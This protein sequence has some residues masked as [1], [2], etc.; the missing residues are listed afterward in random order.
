MTS[1]THLS[2]LF[3]MTIMVA[4]NFFS[5]GSNAVGNSGRIDIGIYSTGCSGFEV[6]LTPNAGFTDNTITNIQFTISWPQNTVNLINLNKNFNIEQQG[7]VQVANGMNHAIFASTEPVAVNWIAQTQYTLI[8]FS[9]DA[10][11]SGYG[12]FFIDESPWVVANNGMFYTEL[13]GIDLTGNVIH[14]VKNIFMG[15]CGI[16]EIRVLL[17]G[18]YNSVTGLM[19]T[20][21]NTAGTLPKNQTF[22]MPPWN[23]SGTEQVSSFPDSI[24]DWVLVELRDKTNTTQT[25]ERKAGLLSKSGLV[26]SADMT[27]GLFFNSI[28]NLSEFYI[29]VWHR[30]HMPVMSGLTVSFPNPGKPY[31]FSRITSTQPYKHNNPLPAE[32][33]LAVEGSGIYGMIAGDINGDKQLVYSGSGNDRALILSKIGTISGSNLLNASINGYY[34]EDITVDNQVDYTGASNDR[35]LILSNLNRLTGSSNLNIVYFSVVP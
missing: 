23:Y 19:S 2:R 4:I 30:N 7:P 13:L 31:D 10:S 25:I 27:S 8:S 12:S 33:E 14:D 26:L 15:R 18:P 16:A 6:R 20:A 32:L 29:V 22:N 5:F 11:G 28:G 1:L 21:L 3:L 35:A 24:V 34:N 17:Q 9:H